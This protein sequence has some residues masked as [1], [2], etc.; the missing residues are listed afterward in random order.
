MRIE[1]E[2]LEIPPLSPG[3]QSLVS[4]HSLFNALNVLRCELVLA[5]LAAADD[6][7]FFPQSVR[8]CD[9]YRRMLR[10]PITAA[11]HLE[12]VDAL[13][14]TVAS[15]FQDE[16]RL[17]LKL[18]HYCD[19]ELCRSNLTSV[20]RILRV[21]AC[22][23]ASRES[24][25]GRWHRFSLQRLRRNLLE[26]LLAQQAVTRKGFRIVTDVQHQRSGDYCV[27]L[28]IYSQNGLHLTMP[29]E[30]EDVFRDLIANARKYSAAGTRILASLVEHPDGIRLEVDDTG[31]GIP[32][33]Q[34]EQVVHF[35]KRA[36]NV[37]NVR[38]MG[39]GFGLTKAF[40]ITKRYGG[41]FWINSELQAGTTVR[42]WI[43][44]P[45]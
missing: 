23:I 24:L 8:A 11:V 32:P 45:S 13:E 29:P 26:F 35:G 41:R 10:E 22:E 28:G 14:R 9:R 31:R 36:S 1:K 42:L 44:Q 6:P 20:L 21:R 30:L 3:E 5:G 4:A 16:L 25:G 18:A 7:D 33:D 2:I 39:A 15:E 40:L 19:L 34:I 37:D 38:T 43:P 27:S 17:H 12:C